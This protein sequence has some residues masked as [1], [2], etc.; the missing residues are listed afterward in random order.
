MQTFFANFIK[1]GKPDGRGVPKWPAA[2]SG[3]VTK[4]MVIDVTPHVIDDPRGPRYRF[5][6]SVYGN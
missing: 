1:T 4:R 5:L 6:D 3:A 2:K